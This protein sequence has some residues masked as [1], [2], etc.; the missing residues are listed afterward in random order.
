[1]SSTVTSSTD[2]ESE[3]N[4]SVTI[5]FEWTLRGLKNLFD[6]SKGDAKSKTTKSMRFGGGRWQILFYANAGTTKEGSVPNSEGG[7]Y[8]SLYLSCEPT[9]EERDAVGDSG[10]YGYTLIDLHPSDLHSL[11]KTQVYNLKEAHNHTFSYKTQNWGWAQF[12]KR[13]NIYYN[14]NG[15]KN[16]DAFIITCTITSSPAPPNPP[17]AHRIQTVPKRLLETVGDL[18]DDPLYSDVEFVIPGR[19]GDV[20]SARKILASKALLRRA[21]YFESMFGSDFVEGSS[22]Q[23]QTAMDVQ[24]TANVIDSE[25]DIFMHEFEDSDDEDEAE[26]V[27]A[28]ADADNNSSQPSP[29]LKPD[30]TSVSQSTS[31]EVE[32]EGEQRNVRAKL[33]HPSSPRTSAAPLSDGPVSPRSSVIVKDVAYTTYMA[34]LY[35]LYTDIIVFAPLSSSFLPKA[36]ADPPA[37]TNQCQ[38]PSDASALKTSPQDAP[39]SRQ[40]WIHLWKETHPDRPAPCSAKA[41]YRLAD[42]LDLPELKARA[43]QHIVKALNVDNIAYE[44]FTPFAAMFEDIRKVQIDFFLAHWKDIRAS[45]SMR[46]VWQ[47]IRNGRHP[48]FEEVWPAIAS[49]LEFKPTQKAT[50]TKTPDAAG[51]TSR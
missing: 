27:T 11:A 44:I 25:G 38:S 49:N 1:M 14:S 16:Q 29:A 33:S 41:M 43:S 36:E 20:K 39:S 40:E 32:V 2:P 50:P 42:R 47:Q 45:D 4:Q 28:R 12:A 7:G 51:D 13:D 30:E 17:P 9:Q 5:T 48:G 24:P 31:D 35:Y 23:L 6:S 3:Y 10:K 19:R 15:V 22:E 26:L 18:L 34:L 8:V 37:D 46:N 21:D